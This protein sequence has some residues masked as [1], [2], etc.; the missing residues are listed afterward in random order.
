MTQV[1]VSRMEKTDSEKNAGKIFLIPR[2]FFPFFPDTKR[3]SSV[4][5]VQP[6][7]AH[8]RVLAGLNR[9][10]RSRCACYH[11]RIAGRDSGTKEVIGTS[12]RKKM[13][14]VWILVFLLAAAAVCFLP[15]RRER[16][17][18][19]GDADPGGFRGGAPMSQE[20]LYIKID[21]NV[22]VQNEK[23]CLGRD[24]AASVYQPGH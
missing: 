3:D 11:V 23:V 14:F 4:V 2:I 24:R 18:A 19:G 5:T 8:I 9:Y 10:I 17:G 15:C 12:Y 7:S 16:S 21:K 22:Q 13:V 1:Q 6:G 20:T